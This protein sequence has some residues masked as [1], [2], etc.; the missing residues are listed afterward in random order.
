M[1]GDHG[2]SRRNSD[3]VCDEAVNYAPAH[4]R[5]AIAYAKIAIFRAS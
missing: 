4:I 1:G 2:G 3:L 5:G